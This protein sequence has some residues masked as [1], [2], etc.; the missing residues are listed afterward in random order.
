MNSPA[1]L[2]AFWSSFGWK[3]YE[4]NT[5]PENVFDQRDQYI[6]Y[7]DPESDFD[8]PVMATASL[9]QRSR[10]WTDTVEKAQQIM[11][12]IGMGGVIV[13]FDGGAMWIKRGVPFSQRMSDEDPAIRRIYI[14]VE[15]EYIK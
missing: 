8:H 13:A 1:A 9:W 12:Y 7:S 14:N 10:S 2:Q 4:E 15:I 11:N 6:T 3:A 5:V